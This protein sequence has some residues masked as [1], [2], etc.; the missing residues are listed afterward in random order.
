MTYRRPFRR[1]ILQSAVR[2]LMDARVFMMLVLFLVPECDATLAQIV[3]TH[4]DFHAIT[5]QDFDVI[6]PHL[7][8]DVGH[9]GVPILKL[10]SK[11]RV[12][13]RFQDGAILCDRRLFRHTVSQFVFFEFK[14]SSMSLKLERTSAFP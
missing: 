13:E 6:H 4:L 8:R 12:G 5:W 7:P 9:D 2:F 14:T 3:G 1:T 11:A 10:H